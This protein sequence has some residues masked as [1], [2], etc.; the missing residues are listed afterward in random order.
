MAE[1]PAAA[2]KAATRTM[3]IILA[4][5][6]VIA[7][8]AWFLMGQNRAPGPLAQD[9]EKTQTEQAMEDTVI[10]NPD[11]TAVQQVPTQADTLTEGGQ[12]L[13]APVVTDEQGSPTGGVGPATVTPNT[14]Q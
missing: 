11:G 10:V 9:P 2:P 8:L 14:A 12:A 1:Q 7:L 13:P 4:A 6:V 3:V 5:L